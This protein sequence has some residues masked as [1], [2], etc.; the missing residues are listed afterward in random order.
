MIESE[1]D[2]YALVCDQCGEEVNF[3][4]FQEAVDYKKENG[5]KSRK[6]KYGCW[7]D[8]CPDCAND[9]RVK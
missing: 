9:F 3:Y 4:T 5:W 2:G 6:D 1:R 7:E 8:I